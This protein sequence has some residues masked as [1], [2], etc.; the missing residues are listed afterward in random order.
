MTESIGEYALYAFNGSI[1]M[2]TKSRELHTNV[3]VWKKVEE[4]TISLGTRGFTLG[5][6]PVHRMGDF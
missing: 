2:S 5:L 1:K 4:R 3:F 6:S